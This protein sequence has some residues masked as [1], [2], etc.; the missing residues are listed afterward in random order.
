[1]FGKCLYQNQLTYI[2]QQNYE[3]SKQGGDNSIVY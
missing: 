2:I 1:M 3:Q